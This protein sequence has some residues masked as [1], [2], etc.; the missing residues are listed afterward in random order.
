[1]L[2]QKKEI[3]FNDA[4]EQT[5]ATACFT[6]LTNL[7]NT[8]Y[9]IYMRNLFFSVLCL[10]ICT[11]NAQ[12]VQWNASRILLEIEKLNTTASVLYIAAHPDD[13][14]TRLITYLANEKR[15]RTGY[16]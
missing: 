7:I 13:E 6:Y 14:N 10:L 12:Q 9:H 11:S 8:I 3:G 16:L 4:G 5:I 15:V 1:M 2:L